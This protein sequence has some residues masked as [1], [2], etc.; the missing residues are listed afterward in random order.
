MRLGLLGRG[1]PSRWRRSAKCGSGRL[2]TRNRISCLPAERGS[3]WRNDS[4][5]PVSKTTSIE[6]ASAISSSRLRGTVPRPPD[7]L[8]RL[9]EKRI[10][11]QPPPQ[12]KSWI[13]TPETPQPLHTHAP[14]IHARPLRRVRKWV[15]KVRGTRLAVRNTPDVLPAN[16]GFL[17]QPGQPAQRRHRALARA[18]QTPKQWR[19]WV[20]PFPLKQI[21]HRNAPKPGLHTGELANRRTGEPA[22]WRTGEPANRPTG[23][24]ANHRTGGLANHQT[25]ELANR[26]T[27]EPANRR[28]TKPANWRTGRLTNWQ[29]GELTN[30]RTGKPANWRTGKLANRQTGELANWRTGKLANWQTGI[31]FLTPFPE[32]RTLPR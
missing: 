18:A 27:G 21:N 26:Q 23:Q 24:L 29:T 14:K 28:T 5:P 8:H 20:S 30:W 4:P 9:V 12:P 32:M 16:A 11:S 7:C 31:I 15:E 22:N 10:Q 25:G 13:H 2:A 1:N 17:I 19:R 3:L 6:R